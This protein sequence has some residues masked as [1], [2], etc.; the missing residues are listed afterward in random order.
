MLLKK[1]ERAGRNGGL[2]EVPA[3]K[4]RVPEEME[5]QVAVN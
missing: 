2:S 5:T 3:K 4:R 1:R